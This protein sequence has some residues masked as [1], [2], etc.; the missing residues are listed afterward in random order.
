MSTIL[1]FNTAAQAGMDREHEVQLSLL[2]TLC[3]AIREQRNAGEVA[4][5]LEQFSAYCEAHFVSEEL[6]MRQNSFDEYEDHADDHC[7]M[8][9]LLKVIAID[10]ATGKSSELKAVTDEALA[11]IENHIRTRD[12]RFADFLR[13]TP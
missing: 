1:D 6:I 9:D 7:H 4:Q 8:M 11:F 13:T 10:H 3:Q 2:R 5:L 12:Q